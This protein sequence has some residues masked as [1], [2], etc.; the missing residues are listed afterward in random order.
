MLKHKYQMNT[1]R[2]RLCPPLLLSNISSSSSKDLNL[3]YSTMSWISKLQQS[4][5]IHLDKFLCVYLGCNCVRTNFPLHPLSHMHDH[6]P[7]Q[8]CPF[9]FDH[10]LACKMTRSST[11]SLFI[12]ITVYSSLHYHGSKYHLKAYT[13]TGMFSPFVLWACVCDWH[14]KDTDISHRI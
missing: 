1:I 14:E 7:S 8:E 12:T 10:T 11:F 5:S 3:Q 4:Y 13:N 6:T 9:S 2:K